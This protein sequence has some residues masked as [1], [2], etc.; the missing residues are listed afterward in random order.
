[1]NSDEDFADR[2]TY[3]PGAHSGVVRLRIEL[4]TIE[5]KIEVLSGLFTM[6]AP[7]ALFG[8]LAIVVNHA[9]ES[10]ARRI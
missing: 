1:M 4:T 2:R 9:S 5:H 10:L 6:F 7:A 3:P 8:K